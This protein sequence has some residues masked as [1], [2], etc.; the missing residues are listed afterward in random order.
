MRSHDSGKP[1][2]VRAFMAPTRGEFAPLRGAPRLH[3][4]VQ[5]EYELIQTD[6]PQRGPWKV[7]TSRYRYHV[8]SDDMTEVILFHWLPG[9]KCST[10]DPHLHV[11]HSQLTSGAV[12]TRKTHV[13][14]GRVSLE[15]VIR[16]LITEFGVIPLRTDWSEL[17]AECE[18]RFQQFRTWS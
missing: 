3:L 11:G 6:D 16:L 13:P 10:E 14:T 4:S 8:L 2:A 18:A 17:L 12:L 5:M 7:S 1:G 15:S 9:G